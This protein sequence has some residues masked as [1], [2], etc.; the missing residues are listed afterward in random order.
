MGDLSGMPFHFCLKNSLRMT[1]LRFL[2]RRFLA[3]EGIFGH[4]IRA[5]VLL[6]IGRVFPPTSAGACNSSVNA[7]PRPAHTFPFSRR[8]TSNVTDLWES[9]GAT[10][11]GQRDTPGTPP[12]GPPQPESDPPTPVALAALE[13]DLSSP[14][15]PFGLKQR[16]ALAA[17]RWV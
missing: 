2:S 16:S 12:S 17:G 9:P 15:A 8:T 13:A 7:W 3:F 5:F 10:S 1:F 4:K 14:A 11:A 6:I